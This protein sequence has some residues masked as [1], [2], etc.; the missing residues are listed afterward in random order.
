[1]SSRFVASVVGSLKLNKTNKEHDYNPARLVDC[2]GNLSKRWYVVFYIWNED[3]RK[4]QRVRLYDVNDF[5]TAEERYL[6]GDALVKEINEKLKQGYVLS[7]S[8]LSLP[9]VINPLNLSL[10]G[11]IE[12]HINKNRKTLSAATIKDYNTLLNTLSAWL[13]LNNIAGLHLQNFSLEIANQFFQ[14]LTDEKVKRD[15]TKGV[16]NKTYNNYLTYFQTIYNDLEENEYITKSQNILKKL[17]RKKAKSGKHIPYSSG[18]LQLI[19]KALTEA[20]ELQTLLFIKFIYYT[21][22]RPKKELRF[23]KVGD[24]HENVVYISSENAK[25]NGRFATIPDDLNALIRK[26]KIRK[27][28]ANFYVFSTTGQPGPE[29][30]VR[31]YFYKKNKEILKQLK[32]TDQEYTLYG[33]KHTGNIHLSWL[34]RIFTW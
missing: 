23:L 21:F 2:S 8:K 11:I 13:E 6:A 31:D 24:L 28:P 7:D 19:E 3:T 27:F 29:P 25:G 9:V 10:A 20:G 16:A 33:Y 32:F 30:T 5:A 26:Y 14:Y 17:K 18:Q 15:G 22:A 1:M 4:K 12:R 34:L